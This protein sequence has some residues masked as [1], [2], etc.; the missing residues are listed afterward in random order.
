MVYLNR[1]E[2]IVLIFAGVISIGI[3]LLVTDYMDKEST[4]KVKI[5]MEG[6]VLKRLNLFRRK[7][8]S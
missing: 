5:S 6:S 2:K 3:V 1:D 7:M 4:I 8:V